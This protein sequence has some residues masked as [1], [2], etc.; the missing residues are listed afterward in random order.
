MI[1]VDP[2]S[3]ADTATY[4]APLGEAVGI[5]DVL[6]AG[7]PVLR[8]GVMTDCTPGAGLRR[9]DARAPGKGR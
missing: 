5:D 2:A 1:V 7:R 8:S 6:V 4:D 3:V 9:D